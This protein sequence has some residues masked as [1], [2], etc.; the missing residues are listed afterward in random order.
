MGAT[1]AIKQSVHFAGSNLAFK[2]Y[3]KVRFLGTTPPMGCYSVWESHVAVLRKFTASEPFGGVDGGECPAAIA[4]L[5]QRSG[6]KRTP[7]GLK[8]RLRRSPSVSAER[9]HNTFLALTCGD[10]GQ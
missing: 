1:P 8:A 5:S 7:P 3:A 9:T 4:H 6:L 2:Q 10:D